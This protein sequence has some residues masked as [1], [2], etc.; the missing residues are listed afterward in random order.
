[1]TAVLVWL[2]YINVALAVFN[3]IPGFPLDGGGCCAR[4]CW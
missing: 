2:G 1:M 3:L 4:S